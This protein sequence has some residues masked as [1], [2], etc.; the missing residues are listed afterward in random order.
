MWNFLTQREATSLSR[1][2]LALPP[3]ACGP[4]LRRELH[5]RFLTAGPP[6]GAHR[7]AAF[8]RGIRRG[9]KPL[10]APRLDKERP[11]RDPG[12]ALH[13]PPR[14]DLEEMPVDH[15]NEGLKLVPRV[16]CCPTIHQLGEDPQEMGIH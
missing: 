11:T 3:S 8:S 9:T 5:R 6:P 7:T 2:A 12:T 16:L 10:R 4:L 15:G 1:H 14:T 13:D